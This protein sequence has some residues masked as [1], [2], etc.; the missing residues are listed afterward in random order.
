MEEETGRSALAS[1]GSQTPVDE[2]KGK[3]RF[4]LHKGNKEEKGKKRFLLH[5]GNKIIDL[6]STNK[7]KVNL[8]FII[9]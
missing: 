4:L 6:R 7:T 5:K 8:R 9:T 1:A 3:K 2:E